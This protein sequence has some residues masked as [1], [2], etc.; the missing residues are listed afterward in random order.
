MKVADIVRWWVD[1]RYPDAWCVSVDDV[2]PT[3][4]PGCYR[5]TAGV[6]I[7][8]PLHDVMIRLDTVI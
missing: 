1:Q 7:P 8:G 5:A 3:V 4:E 6:S 2:A